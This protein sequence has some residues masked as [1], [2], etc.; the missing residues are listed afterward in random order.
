MIGGDHAD[1]ATGN[2]IFYE[3]IKDLIYVT[4]S[5]KTLHVSVQ[6]LAYF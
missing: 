6:I 2:I 3:E 1:T 5:A 4:V